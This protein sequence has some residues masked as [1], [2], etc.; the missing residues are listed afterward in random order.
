VTGGAHDT[1]SDELANSLRR[2]MYDLPMDELAA[3]EQRAILDLAD[4][5]LPDWRRFA[6]AQ[7]AAERERIA[8][9]IDQDFRDKAFL[10]Q[11]VFD[12]WRGRRDACHV[13]AR[14]AR[15]QP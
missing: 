10:T 12:Y 1:L 15:G 11:E 13:A 4:A 8:A 7:V 2:A 5:L 3:D 6:D 14:I 9:A